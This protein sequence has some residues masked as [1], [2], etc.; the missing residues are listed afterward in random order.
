MDDLLKGLVL[1]GGTPIDS[2]KQQL[3]QVLSIC[4]IKTNS[5]KI[6]QLKHFSESHIVLHNKPFKHRNTNAQRYFTQTHTDN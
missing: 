6:K 3:F 5:Y 2:M 4:Q 1:L